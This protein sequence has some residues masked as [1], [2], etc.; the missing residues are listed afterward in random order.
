MDP[1]ARVGPSP[2][3][4]G[5]R[6]AGAPRVVAGGA[7]GLRN[8]QGYRYALWKRG[9]GASGHS[10]LKATIGRESTQE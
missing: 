7:H 1:T 5:S 8:R 2:A 3:P 6:A 9:P 4:S 10:E